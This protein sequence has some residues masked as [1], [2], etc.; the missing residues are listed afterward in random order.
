MKNNMVEEALNHLEKG[1]MN[2][3]FNHEGYC[4]SV[5]M[6]E[7]IEEKVALFKNIFS[8]DIIFAKHMELETLKSSI[9]ECS[10]CGERYVFVYQS[11]EMKEMKQ[12][13]NDNDVVYEETLCK[14]AVA[15]EFEVDFPSGVLI[16]DDRLPYSYD[17]LINL[18]RDNKATLNSKA[19]RVNLTDKHALKNI[20]HVYSGDTSPALYKAGDTL[21][22]NQTIDN[23]NSPCHCGENNCDCDYTEYA[24]IKN[25]VKIGETTTDLHWVSLVDLEVYKELLIKF[26]GPTQANEYITKLKPLSMTVTPGKYKCTYYGEENIICKLELV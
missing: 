13:I 18:G 12:V 17:M 7:D 3:S 22:I 25:G 1:T 4:Q 11:G 20:L 8:S 9:E 23:E 15:H 26:Y 5:F 24:P 21:I 14:K 16:Y 6:G 10:D 19:G 2:L